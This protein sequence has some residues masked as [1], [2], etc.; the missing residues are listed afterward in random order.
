MREDPAIRRM[1][2]DSKQMYIDI[3]SGIALSAPTGALYAIMCQY[4]QAVSKLVLLHSVHILATVV[5]D[6]YSSINTYEQPIQLTQLDKT[7]VI[8]LFSN[9]QSVSTSPDCNATATD[10]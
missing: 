8:S 3:L 10:M 7:Q 1:L 9:C 4:H 6:C 5:P 2:F